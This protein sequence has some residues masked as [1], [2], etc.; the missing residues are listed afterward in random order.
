LQADEFSAVGLWLDLMK[1]ELWWCLK[2]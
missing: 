1:P 2:G